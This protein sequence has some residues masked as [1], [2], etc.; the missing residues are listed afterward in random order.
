VVT[1]DKA[2][3]FLLIDV[4][5]DSPERGRLFPTVAATA[6]TDDYIPENLLAVAARPGFVL[7]P[8]R[9]Y[10]FVVQ[11]SLGDAAGKKLDVADTLEALSAGKTP[12]G[13]LGE[14]AA[15]LY[16][17]LWGTLDKIGIPRTDVAAATVFTTGDV[18]QSTFD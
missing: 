17:P 14:E 8:M 5:P 16:A 13:P 7:K 9:K 10:A 15:M 12:E 1:A 11:R 6:E 2:S 4:D 18:V 3:P